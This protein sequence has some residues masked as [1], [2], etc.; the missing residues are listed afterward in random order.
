MWAKTIVGDKTQYYINSC[1]YGVAIARQSNHPASLA[2]QMGHDRIENFFV[3]DNNT[4]LYKYSHWPKPSDKLPDGVYQLYN[5]SY[6]DWLEPTKTEDKFIGS[7]LNDDILKD[8]NLFL[9]N[10]DHYRKL[11]IPHK[12]G[13]LFYGPP[14]NG[15]TNAILSLVPKINIDGAIW[16]FVNGKLGQTQT[17]DHIIK[18]ENRRLKIIVLEELVTHTNG[19]SKQ[20]LNLLD[21]VNGLDNFIVIATTNYPEEIP[22]NIIQRPSRFDIVRHIDLPDYNTVGKIIEFYLERSPTE[23]E[24]SLMLGLSCA[25]IKEACLRVTLFTSTLEKEKNNFKELEQLVQKNFAKSRKSDGFG[26]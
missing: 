22:S 5:A 26:F 24:V 13:Y 12:R 8:M 1:E 6:S 19:D 25:M 10:K 14:G 7:S 16:I 20:L 4:I 21:G 3:L 2:K 11:N 18:H 17:W 9:S 23:Q 15:K